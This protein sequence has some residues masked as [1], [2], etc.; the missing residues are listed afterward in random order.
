MRA[1]ASFALLTIVLPWLAIAQSN[2]PSFEV[3]S[4]RPGVFLPPGPDGVVR[5]GSH[6]GPGTNDPENYSAR[7]VT[8]ASLVLR[9]YGLRSYQ[10]SGPNWMDSARYDIA[11]K[12][13]AGATPAQFKLMLQSLL[14]DHFTLKF[15]YQKRDF[16]G[17]E[18]SLAKGGLKLVDAVNLRNLSSPPKS[19]IAKAATAEGDG[20]INDLVIRQY[21]GRVLTGRSTTMSNLAYN[22]GFSLGGV[23]V[24][25]VT[26]LTDAYDLVLPY[27][28]PV[29]TL[30]DVPSSFPSIFTVLQAVGLKLEAKK[31]PLD[32]LVVDQIQQTPSEN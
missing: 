21:V 30:S 16:S 18:L 24:V 6:G 20:N 14:V 25:D 8:L 13:S 5:T 3:A 26:G 10:L 4:V 28:P 19:G 23:P 27:D 1:A 12:V 15:H 31:M 2:G 7:Y 32:V 22:L 17:Y 11:A 9:A 29:A